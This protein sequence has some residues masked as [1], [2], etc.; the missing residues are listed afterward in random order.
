VQPQLERKL[1]CKRYRI[2]ESDNDDDDDD[3][4]NDNNMHSLVLRMPLL[5][6][7]ITEAD[8]EVGTASVVLWSDPEVPVSIPGATRF[9]EK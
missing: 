2:I 1:R 5:R 8:S 6:H 7:L 9:S 4:D 3:N